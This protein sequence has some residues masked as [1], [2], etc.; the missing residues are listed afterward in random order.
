MEIFSRLVLH[1]LDGIVYGWLYA[2]I[3]FGLSLIFGLLNVVNV[4]HGT[5]Y[6]LGAVFGWYFAA[7]LTG[8][9][10][11]LALVMAPVVVCV[12]SMVIEVVVLRPI[13]EDPDMTIL[14]TFGI[15][16]IVENI[17][18]LWIG[19][20]GV[21]FDSPFQGSIPVIGYNYSLYRIFVMGVAI[22]AALGLWWFL[23][24]TKYGLWI[25][26]VRMNTDL[27]LADGIPVKSVNTVAFG[28]GGLLAGLSG[29]LAG[30][31]IAI[32]PTMGLNVLIIA[33]I[34]VIVGGLGDPFGAVV[35][36]LIL[37]YVESIASIFVEPTY[38]RVLA[39]LFVTSFLFFRPNGLFGR[40]R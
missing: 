2:L 22:A 37:G 6:M 36:G 25:R 32:F 15:L 40:G 29:V 9:N 35:A 34:V 3:A 28:L 10:F 5:L 19:G 8:G 11:W 39:L 21:T 27:S 4:A 26:A 23:Q 16:L 18:L 12:F 7:T 24:K 20:Q 30:P 13:E 1:S 31:F 33:F 38:A 14:S 17:I